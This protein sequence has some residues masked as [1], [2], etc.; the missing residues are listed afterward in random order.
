MLVTVEHGVA[1]RVTGDPD[2][3]IT[4]GFLCGKVSNYLDRVYGDQRLLEPLIRTGE[5]G[6]GRFRPASWDEALELVAERLRAAI[7]A[8][9]GETVLPY[10]YLGT[11]G[12]LQNDSM[13]ARVF[14][15]LGASA[16]E[17][18]I[19][20]T[21]GLMGTTAAHGLSPEVDPEL[22]P[23]ARYIICWGWNPMST[24]P[25][26]WRQ[27]L[28]ARR[29]GAKLVVVDPFR[30]RTARVADEH[31]R[32]LPGTD[33]A[34]ALGMMRALVDAGAQDA[35]WC[36]AHA[37]GYDD[38]LTTLEPYPVD[39]CAAITGVPA[40]AIARVAH[41]FAGTQPSLLRL[42]VGAQ[43]HK[44][45]PAAYR[46]VAALPALAGSWRHVGGGC[47]YIP[48]ATAAAVDSSR[49]RREDLRPSP[50]RTINMS[51]LGDALT[52]PAL[53]PPVTALVCWNSNPAAIAPDQT[54]VLAGLARTDLFTVVLE[55]VMTDSARWA[56]VVLPATTQL[57]HLDAV[58]SWGHHYVTYNAPAIAPRGQALSNT[59]IFRRLAAHLGLDDPCFSESDEAMLASLFADA[60]GGVTLEALRE[61][62]WV[63][64]DVGQTAAPHAGGGF[65]T[66]DGRIVLSAVYEP[67]AEVADEQLA[68]RYP[69]ALVT[70]K[71]HLFLN[72]TFADQR[73]QRAA[74][75][76]PYLVIHPDDAAP[77]AIA[78]GDLVRVF[79]DRGAFTARARVSDDARIEV[80]VAPMGWW[81]A[82]HPSGV[83]A[84]ATTSQ[85]L[86]EHGRAP[87]FNDNRVEV[88]R[89]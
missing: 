23:H 33:A 20:A 83:A 57:E 69:L 50:V 1:T 49:L 4:A 74:Q 24:A 11:M 88:T 10:S 77:R 61:R 12:Y 73:R 30:S 3:P 84:Q 56:D 18:T 16:L 58:F 9:G 71:T 28:A 26:L 19:C 41:E 82:D 2:H 17:R 70:P 62:G 37:S 63:K 38:L 72:T 45:A 75:P 15:A 35:E 44:G 32:P 7:D 68:R 27:I 39:R 52:D 47:A 89:A 80:V 34:L 79:N 25:H 48:T 53:S 76:E 21:A 22:W 64:V 31:L 78:D 29:A 66:P 5:K 43:R 60:P 14:N 55:Q 6:E 59:E 46:T 65:G 67:P 54:K 85:A 8:H 51:Q 42:G 87:T 86:T 36:R 81:N 13:S 40:D